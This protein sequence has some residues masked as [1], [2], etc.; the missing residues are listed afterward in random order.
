M[1]SLV[2][3]VA[4]APFAAYHFHRLADYGVLA[5]MIAVPI[6]GFWVMPLAVLA[7]ALM[8]FGLEAFALEPMG[9]GIEAIVWV[10]RSVAALPGAA[11]QI[12][13][14]PAEALGLFVLGG[15]W[16]CLWRGLWRWLGLA[17]VP[18]AVL[19]ALLDRPPDLLISADGAVVA[20]RD[21]SGELRLTD[22]RKGG[23]AVETWLERNGQEQRLAWPEPPAGGCDAEGCRAEQQGRQVAVA[24]S[25]AAAVEECGRADLVISARFLKRSRCR[26]S[27]LIDRGALWRMGPHAVWLTEEGVRVDTVRAFRGERPWVAGRDRPPGYLPEF[28]PWPDQ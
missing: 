19:I 11:I 15:L 1:T 7:F 21:A 5:N 4:T 16:I 14:I 22:P 25:A 23:I 17:A 10:A 13:A 27:L 2:A 6:T 8:P 24:V 3:G 20:L 12:R 18:A 28:L 9:W 26:G